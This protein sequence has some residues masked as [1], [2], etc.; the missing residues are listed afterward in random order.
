MVALQVLV[1]SIQNE[2]KQQVKYYDVFVKMMWSF[3]V[4]L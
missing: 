2:A 1:A 3:K 4:F